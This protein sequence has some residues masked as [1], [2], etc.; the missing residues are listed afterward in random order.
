MP[1]L[2]KRQWTPCRSTLLP[3]ETLELN[4]CLGQWSNVIVQVP[5][6]CTQLHTFVTING[7]YKFDTQL[8]IDLDPDAGSLGPWKCESTLNELMVAISGI[9]RPDS[10]GDSV[11]EDLPGQKQE[12]HDRL[13]RSAC[14]TDPAWKPC[15]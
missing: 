6:S 14:P 13:F 7:E 10:D 5:R 8:L 3:S 4:E 15:G 11:E 9:P 1:S 2:E 12:M